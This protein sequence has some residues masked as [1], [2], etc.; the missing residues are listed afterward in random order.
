MVLLELRQLLEE[1]RQRLSI[2]RAKVGLHS[3]IGRL[4]KIEDG[5]KVR[6]HLL[7]CINDLTHVEL[8]LE[9]RIRWE[10]V[11]DEMD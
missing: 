5:L 1:H 3:R 9:A 11:R 2:V 7:Q 8:L 10:V 4:D 6:L